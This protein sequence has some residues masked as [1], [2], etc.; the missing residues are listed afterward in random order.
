MRAS[1]GRGGLFQGKLVLN[2]FVY[3]VTVPGNSAHPQKLSTDPQVETVEIIL[4]E[5][6]NV[7][8]LQ[9]MSLRYYGEMRQ[10]RP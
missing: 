8:P 7:S 3:L 10:H 1:S 6:E 2:V 5:P 4:K 9:G